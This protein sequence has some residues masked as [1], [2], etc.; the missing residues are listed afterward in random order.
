[1]SFFEVALRNAGHGCIQHIL[2]RDGKR[3]AAG[4]SGLDIEERFD[5]SPRRRSRI[6]SRSTCLKDQAARGR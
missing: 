1:M 2:Q 3:E 5:A 4:A 6:R